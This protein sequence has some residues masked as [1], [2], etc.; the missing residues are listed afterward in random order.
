[1]TTFLLRRAVGAVWVV[2]GVAVTV[3][4]ILHLTGDPA[5]VMMPPDATTE[6]VA[7]FRHNQGF[8]RPLY[9]QFGSFAWNALRGDFGNSLR[10]GEPALGLALERFP[11][12]FE[13]AISALLLAIVVAVPIGILAAVR[14][15]SPVDLA[16]RVFALI[17]QSAPVYWMGIMLILIFGVQLGW[18]PVSGIGGIR[19]LVLPTVTLALF[20]MAQLM[21]LTRASMLDVM[22]SDYLRTARAKGVAPLVV[23]WKHA[24]RN[25]WLPVIT[26]IGTELVTLFSQAV[27]TETIYSWPGVAR[28]AV[29]AIVDRDYPI[30]EVVV[31]LAALA[32]V[33][34][35]L[36]VDLLYA[37]LDPR[38]RYE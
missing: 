34:I 27:I 28:L 19:H 17:G 26:V 36:L 5:A 13:L 12:S 35:N 20:T 16:A 10:H 7:A 4:L 38:I 14:R 30:V 22:Q 23:L 2:V 9:V 31:I 11:A 32:F 29:Q 18:F 15:N 1:M 25:A 24:L 8:D 37:S 33:A 21:R 6:Q 3:F